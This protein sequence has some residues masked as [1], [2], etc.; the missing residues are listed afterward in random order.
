LAANGSA[1][2]TVN[3]SLGQRITSLIR[4]FSEAGGMQAER[5]IDSAS[6]AK[7]MTGSPGISSAIFRNTSASA[8]EGRIVI[9]RVSEFLSGGD[10]I[11][12]EQKNSGGR[13]VINLNREN[14]PAILGS[15]SPDIT[16][17]LTAILAPIAIGDEM[18]KTEYLDLVASFYNRTV[19]DEIASSKIR[20]SI[21]FPAN[22][23]AV[24]GGTSSGRRA[25]FEISVL[26]LLVLETPLVYEV[27]W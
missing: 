12:F 15:L 8:V 16:D 17:Y 11:I 3:I 10:F 22:V 20:A 26:D 5:I 24:K 27:I 14:V 7:S 19:S 1:D 23:T 13:C 6:I 2:I 9:S 4:S 18:T 21:E 25:V